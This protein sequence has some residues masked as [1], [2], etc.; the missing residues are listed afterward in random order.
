MS[1]DTYI[2]IATGSHLCRNPRVVKE[3][4][5]LAEAEYEVTV[6]GPIFNDELREEDQDLLENASWQYTP[7][8]DLRRQVEGSWARVQRKIGSYLTEYGWESS[9]ALGYGVGQTLRRARAEQADFYIGHEEVGL[10]TAWRLQKEGARVGADIEDWHSRDLLPK[11][12][13][14]RPTG[15]L[16]RVEHDLLNNAAHVTTTSR[17]MAQGMAEAYDAPVPTVLYNAFPLADRE[18]IG[19]RARDRDGSGRISLHWVSQTVGPG[20]GLETLCRALER[21]DT[22]LQ[23]H[24]RGQ[25]GDD[26]RSRLDRVF[27]TEKGHALYIHN[28][29]SPGDL[30]DRIAEHD[31]GLALEQYEPES[32]NRTVTNKILHYLLGGLAVVA[33]DTTG[34]QEVAQMGG[35]A[36][37]LCSPNNVDGLARQI[38]DLVRSKE[39]LERAQT[40]AL[41]SA[42]ETFCWER[43]V[44]K[45]LS[46]VQR[47]LSTSKQYSQ[48]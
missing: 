31:V 2:C 8:V 21:V 1:V 12:R 42:R 3:A 48:P 5:A 23:V 36:V 35:E 11:D 43:Q 25:C 13:A 26:Y 27:P 39:E 47:G 19:E 33:T 37:R 32:R 16:E 4:G 30:L 28:L 15:V 44:P 34:Q 29:V 46:S 6:V 38:H 40:D 41:R 10:W 24:L 20:R 7:S 17:A 18:T 45:L 22:P 9:S 14:G